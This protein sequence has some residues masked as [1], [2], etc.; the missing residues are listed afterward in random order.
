MR[1]IR[2]KRNTVHYLILSSILIGGLALML[3][4]TYFAVSTLKENYKTKELEINKKVAMFERM[5]LVAKTD[6]KAGSVLSEE[7]LVKKKIVCDLGTEDVPLSLMQDM[8]AKVD[9]KEGAIITESVFVTSNACSDKRL[10]GVE[11]ISPCLFLKENDYVDVRISFPNGE[12]FCLL[13]KK[14]V[15]GIEEGIYIFELDERE[16]IC[17]SSAKVD[18]KRY[19]ETCMYL[20]KYEEPDIQKQGKETYIPNLESMALLSS[21]EFGDVNEMVSDDKRLEF[22]GRLDLRTLQKG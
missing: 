10:T 4:F 16:L 19:P 5:V 1:R 20:V 3:S 7:N 14:K 17:V 8:K 21:L 2:M 6:I 18:L 9:I 11:G 13:S 15:R 22:E 12:D